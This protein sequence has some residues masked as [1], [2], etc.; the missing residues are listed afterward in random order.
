MLFR[1]FKHIANVAAKYTFKGGPFDG[2][3]VGGNG[4]IRGRQFR[5]QGIETGSNAGYAIW[6]AF[7]GYSGNWD[8]RKYRIQLNVDNVFDREYLRTY[9]QIGEPLQFILATNLSF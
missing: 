4:V 2:W 3:F 9:G 1:S 7:A 5:Y 6:G 8:S